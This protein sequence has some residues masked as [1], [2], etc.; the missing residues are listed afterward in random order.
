MTYYYAHLIW[1]IV[2]GAAGIYFLLRYAGKGP[3][4]WR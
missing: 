3:R 2:L 1:Y 4:R